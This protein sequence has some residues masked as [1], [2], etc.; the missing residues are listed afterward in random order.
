MLQ[1]II[2]QEAGDH[3]VLTDTRNGRFHLLFVSRD[4]LKS[5][6]YHPHWVTECASE[7]VFE[8]LVR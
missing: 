4:A 7:A 2:E 1:K 5:N 6:P 3:T 8:G